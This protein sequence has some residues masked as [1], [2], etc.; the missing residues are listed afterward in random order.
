MR[1]FLEWVVRPEFVSWAP[2]TQHLTARVNLRSC[3]PVRCSSNLRC[4]RT[5]LSR[6]LQEWGTNAHVCAASAAMTT[7]RM[8]IA[9]EELDAAENNKA[10]TA[11]NVVAVV[12]RATWISAERGALYKRLRLFWSLLLMSVLCRSSTD[13]RSSSTVA[14]DPFAA[15][16]GCCCTGRSVRAKARQVHRSVKCF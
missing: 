12:A 15:T 2:G 5:A 1:S 9:F 14:P 11:S 16:I 4:M 3:C 13:A 8:D 6:C 7:G 10:P